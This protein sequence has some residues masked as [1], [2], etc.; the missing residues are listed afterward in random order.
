[1]GFHLC[2]LLN[3]ALASFTTRCCGSGVCVPSDMCFFL[4]SVVSKNVRLFLIVY[5]CMLLKDSESWK[6]VPSR[7]RCGP[8]PGPVGPTVLRIGPCLVVMIV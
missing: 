6:V 3:D 4:S 8:L 2:Y 7:W 1:M 5:T